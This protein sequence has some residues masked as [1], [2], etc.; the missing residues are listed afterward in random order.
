MV[1]AADLRITPTGTA[2]LRIAVECGAEA[3]GL[4]LMAVMSGEGAREIAAR[5]KPASLVRIAGRLRQAARGKAEIG[6]PGIEVIA[7]SVELVDQKARPA[8]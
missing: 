7:D 1:G 8:T 3:D 5:L 4:T 6:R 2:V